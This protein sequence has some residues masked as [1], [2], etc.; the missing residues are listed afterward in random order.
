MKNEFISQYNHTWNVLE[1]IVD[2]FDD[3]AWTNLGHEYIVPARLAY[4]ILRS[5]QYYIEDNSVITSH[6]ASRSTAT[7]Y[8]WIQ[9]SCL[10]V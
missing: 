6:P 5:T 4:H 7:G 10:R 3:D 2:D 8:R 9:T 1:G